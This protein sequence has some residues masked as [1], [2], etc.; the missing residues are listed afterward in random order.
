MTDYMPISGYISVATGIL[1]TI[2]EILPYIKSIKSNGIMQCILSF[3][4][5]K[6]TSTEHEPLLDADTDVIKTLQE[7]IDGLQVELKR[8]Q[9]TKLVINELED[10]KKITIIIETPCSHDQGDNGI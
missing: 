1:L 4:V 3:L 8:L 6:T 2:S 10:N 5:S 7:R 9:N